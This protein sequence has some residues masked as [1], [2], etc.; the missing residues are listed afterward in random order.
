[1]HRHRPFAR[2]P[3]SAPACLLLI[4]AMGARSA[5]AAPTGQLPAAFVIRAELTRPTGSIASDP[6]TIFL[7]YVDPANC[8]AL[9]ISANEARLVRSVKGQQTVLAGPVALRDGQRARLPVLVIRGPK[10]IDCFVGNAPPLSALDDALSGGRAAHAG[11]EG[12]MAVGEF[13][14]QPLGPIAFSDDFM[15]G[16]KDPDAWEHLAGSWELDRLPNPTWSPNAFRY[17][18]GGR[19]ACLATA[20]NW[21]WHGYAV[22]VAVQPGEECGAAGIALYVEDARNCLLFR[23]RRADGGG[24]SALELVRVASGRETLLASRPADLDP[25]QWYE[26]AVTARGDRLAAFLD[27]RCVAA[28]EAK[29]L[30]CGKV[31]L[32]CRNATRARFDDVAVRSVTASE[33]AMAAAGARLG[34]HLLPERSVRVAAR[35][36]RD[37]YMQQWASELGSWLPDDGQ[38]HTFWNIGFFPSDFA[39]SWHADAPLLFEQG[40]LRIV[41]APE[42]RSEAEGYAF[43]LARDAASGRLNVQLDRR[44]K[45]VAHWTLDVPAGQAVPS[46]DIRRIGSRLEV[47][48]AGKAVGTYTD[49]QPLKTR[50]LGIQCPWTHE[51]VLTAYGGATI[52]ESARPTRLPAI[53]YFHATCPQLRDYAFDRAPVDWMADTGTWEVTPRWICLPLFTWLGGRSHE[54]AVL[55]NKR[56]FARDLTLDV[57]AAVMMNYGPMSGY[58]HYGDLNLT[59]CADGRDLSS[60]YSIL[61]GADG[62]SATRILRR[63]KVVA[64]TTEV[65]YPS[66]NQGAHQN[67]YHLRAEKRGPRILLF[68]GTRL[69]LD[70]TDPEPLEGTQAAIWTWNRGLMV[71]RARVWAERDDG[72]A[73]PA[74]PPQPK[75][76]PTGRPSPIRIVSSSHPGFQFAFDHGAG[77]WHSPTGEHGGTVRWEPRGGGGC[78]RVEN[79]RTGGDFAVFAP[80]TPFDATRLR[81]LSFDYCFDPQVRINLYF[82]THGAW[83]VVGLTGPT[84]PRFH[85]VTESRNIS[86]RTTATTGTQL[87]QPPPIVLGH[88]QA[89]ADGQW[90]T[91]RVDLLSLLRAA[92]PADSHIVVD[93]LHLANWSNDGYLQ[94]GFG[95]NP[96]GAA[97]RV[98]NFFLGS[99]GGGSARFAWWLSGDAPLPQTGW[100]IDQSPD[101]APSPTRAIDAR[102]PAVDG[103]ATGTWFLH[104]AAGPGDGTWSHVRH[105][106]FAV[107]TSPPTASAPEPAPGSQ[108]APRGITAT[109]DDPGNSGISEDSATLTVAGTRLPPQQVRVDGS[110]VA[111]DLRGLAFDDGQT[112]ACELSA[113]D[114]A[115]N[116]MATP[117]RWQWTFDRSLDKSP[118][119]RPALISRRP[120]AWD[121]D[122]ETPSDGWGRFPRSPWVD[123]ALDNATATSGARS[124]RIEGGPGTFRCM[125]RRT[126][127]DARAHPILSFDY[128]ADASTRWSLALLTSRG[129]RPLYV[130]R[131]EHGRRDSRGRPRPKAPPTRDG[132]THANLA[133]GMRLGLQRPGADPVVRAV[134]VFASSTRS[135]QTAVIRIDNLRLVPA[136]FVGD[137]PTLRC[138]AHD[139]SGIQGYSIVVDREPETIP[140]T[141]MNSPTGEAPLGDLRSGYVFLH[142]RALDRAGNWGSPLHQQVYVQRTRDAEPPS[143]AALSPPP[144][145]RVAADRVVVRVGDNETGVAVERVALTVAGERYTMHNPELRFDAAQQAVVWTPPRAHGSPAFADGTTVR[146]AFHAADYAGNPLPEPV[147][148]SWTMDFSQDTAPPATPYVAVVPEGALVWT[149]FEDGPGHW[150]GRREGWAEQTTETAATGL[151]SIRFGGF[152][153]FMYY[154]P[155]DAA[156]FPIVGFDYRLQPEAQLNLMTRVENRNWEIRFNSQGGKYAHIGAVPDVRADGQWHR[157][158]FNL[159]D[160]LRGAPDPPLTLIVDHLA[161]LNRRGEPFHADN[162]FIAPAAWSGVRVQW[163]VPPDPT[164][165]QGYSTALDHAPDAEP[166]ETIDSTRPAAN[167]EHLEPGTW[168]FH[169]RAC[170]GAGNWGPTAHV[171]VEIPVPQE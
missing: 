92:Y 80:L 168:H 16:E 68:V 129:W 38:P 75:P 146:C 114:R 17:A 128:K 34:A 89:T 169:V 52:S 151:G 26:F 7:N 15:R 130:G 136:L 19:G 137:Q 4:A 108:A 90:H 95:G 155:F 85:A 59:L 55:W 86:G 5:A 118:P 106:R 143:V 107:D 140:D 121:E 117:L 10:R 150:M 166:D 127:F 162:F 101:T 28:A 46:L 134:A 132:W 164:G 45:A 88:V 122:F 82:R 24:P 23:W 125:L 30:R 104:V 152:S 54:A 20:G 133:V 72:A 43:T 35:F 112:V 25:R 12:S 147:A 170:D 158:S 42:S 78:L 116:R 33:K 154:R 171:P 29:G 60:G 83:H 98:D 57:H 157:C 41:A 84:G 63:D 115:G 159:A 66:R 27:G 31:G 61:F 9:A 120:P 161:T 58:D 100:C 138:A 14:V 96:R 39:V 11:G 167:Y 99:P 102:S 50:R 148:W 65:L 21:F 91:A 74:A 144:D 18:G 70:Y 6:T 97:Y 94:C 8:Y 40:P 93:D 49:K 13:R 77:G 135:Q 48:A 123:M 109:L 153:S 22:R 51:R 76:L 87:E 79:A 73:L 36:R 142:C 111:A 131:R 37:R 165:I 3:A 53:Q 110:R 44:G 64:E 156:R 1:L 69:A 149:D 160:M 124:L 103:L 113:T 139:P 141:T 126:P 62:N 56:R 163:S 145:A 67:W 47:A 32:Y 2:L 119:T 105:H 81:Q 71:A